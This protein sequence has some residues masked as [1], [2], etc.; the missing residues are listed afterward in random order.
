MNK[1]LA[2]ALCAV[3]ALGLIAASAA[4]LCRRPSQ[5]W[6]PIEG[7][8]VNLARVSTIRATGRLALLCSTTEEEKD[9]LGRTKQSTRVVEVAVL[10]NGPVTADSVAAAKAKLAEAGEWETARGAANLYFDQISVSLEPVREG[11]DAAALSALL[12]TWLEQA[13][14]IDRHMK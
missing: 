2:Y 13:Q 5:V 7:G 1:N 4:L 14:S 3:V 6:Y 9:L 11:A 10:L 8:Y 12:D